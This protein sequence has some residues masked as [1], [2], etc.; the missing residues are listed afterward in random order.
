MSL[1]CGSMQVVAT[2]RLTAQRPELILPPVLDGNRNRIEVGLH[3]AVDLGEHA[4]KLREHGC[5]IRPWGLGKGVARHCD[6]FDALLDAGKEIANAR[7]HVDLLIAAGESLHEAV[8]KFF[9]AEL[10]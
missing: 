9:D 5:I 8:V 3:C 10:G 6:Q 1:Y 7:R 4:A 2:S